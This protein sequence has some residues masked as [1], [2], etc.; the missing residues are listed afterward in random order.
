MVLEFKSDRYVTRCIKYG[1]GCQ[2]RLRASFNKIWGN[3]KK[4]EASHTCLTTVLS[5]DHINLDSTQIVS[6]VANS[7]MTNPLIPVKSLIV[8]IQK[9]SRLLG[10]IQESLEGKTKGS[11]NAIRR[12]EGIV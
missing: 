2:W 11:C 10:V 4:I 1:N 8:E 3:K 5:Q 7:V 6:I 9:S 12:L